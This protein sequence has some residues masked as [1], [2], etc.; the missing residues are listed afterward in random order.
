M[1]FECRSHG[2]EQDCHP[3][4]LGPRLE[5]PTTADPVRWA[6]TDQQVISSIGRLWLQT[7]TLLT[8]APASSTQGLTIDPAIEPF[9]MAGHGSGILSCKFVPHSS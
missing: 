3:T 4:A 6:Q 9:P 7:L 5:L 8:L 2:R 1:V